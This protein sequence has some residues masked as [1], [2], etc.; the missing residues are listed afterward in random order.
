MAAPN[1]QFPGIDAKQSGHRW[2]ATDAEA[3]AAGLAKF[4]RL[5]DGGVEY[6]HAVDRHELEAS[7]AYRLEPWP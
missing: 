5:G 4:I 1:R 2:P 3:R 6:H 7:G